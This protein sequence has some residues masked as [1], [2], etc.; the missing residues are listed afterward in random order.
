M[1]DYEYTPELYH[2]GVK[3]M[4]WGVRRYQN[5]VGSLTPAGKKKYDDDP[6]GQAK[7]AY[8]SAKKDY[9]KAYN[10]AYNRAVAAYSPIKKHRQANDA[11]WEDAAN[12]AENFR[13]AKA[14]YKQ[15]KH[16]EKEAEKTTKALTKQYG[17]LEDGYVYE[18]KTTKKDL[19]RAYGQIEDSLTYNKRSN[20]KANDYAEKA[21]IEIDKQLSQTGKNPAYDAKRV[22]D[23]VDKALKAIEDDLNR[24]TKK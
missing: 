6:V 23:F 21:L 17:K 9:N 19:E 14:D 20:K 4:K 1:Y 15:A 10:K 16:I 2:H 3:G 5:A 7:L 11:R 24:A 22:N 8:K 12:K 18:K 13:K